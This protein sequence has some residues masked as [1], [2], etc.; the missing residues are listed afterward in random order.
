MFYIGDVT[1]PTE[2]DPCQVVKVHFDSDTGYYFTISVDRNGSPFEKQT[3]EDRLRTMSYQEQ[4]NMM[5]ETPESGGSVQVFDPEA[6]DAAAA[7]HPDFHRQETADV[8]MTNEAIYNQHL[9]EEQEALQEQQ[10]QQYGQQQYHQP[11]QQPYGNY[12]DEEN[13]VNTA[14]APPPIYQPQAV[15]AASNPPVNNATSSSQKTKALREENSW[16]TAGLLVACCLL[17]IALGGVGTVLYLWLDDDDDE[18]VVR[19]TPNSPSSTPAPA[20]APTPSPTAAPTLPPGTTAS[21]TTPAPTTPATRDWTITT[22]GTVPRSDPTDFGSSIAM[23]GTNFMVTGEPRF[24]E[25]YAKEGQLLPFQRSG[26]GEAFVDQDVLLEGTEVSV[27]QF[28]TSLDMILDSSSGL[29]LLAVG[30]TRTKGLEQ[31]NDRFG[32]GFYYEYNDSTAMFEPVGGTL[33]AEESLAETGGLLGYSI[34]LAQT[35]DGTKRIALSSPSSSVLESA[36][37]DVGRIYTFELNETAVEPMWEKMTTLPLIGQEANTFL[38]ASI[39][40][41]TDGSFLVAGA[42]GSLPSDGSASGQVLVYQW[43]GD[44]WNSVTVSSNVGS[45]GA[46]MGHRV[47]W[48]SSSNAWFAVSAPTHDSSRGLVRVY[49]R[50]AGDSF[51]PLGNDIVGSSADDMLGSALCGRSGRLATGT[52]DGEFAVY[53]YNSGS[54]DWEVV[55]SP[56]VPVENST[57]VACAMSDDGNTLT[58]GTDTF[59]I[60]VYDLI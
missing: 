18:V 28:G 2:W 31:T 46:S 24:G 10:E 60:F 42:P 9:E 33:R 36:I 52:S 22:A 6:A 3:T 41:W 8:A 19:V 55:G 25:N 14:A 50:G 27:E 26:P 56:F 11:Y 23:A 29:P 37:L 40:L 48:I 49:Q 44:A 15:H 57:V 58:V 13:N 4:M 12:Y 53:E 59:Q 32:A 34:A 5:N 54:G 17:I 7:G 20:T 16:L 51:A 35:P 30:S 43:D 38:G 47:Q 45:A 39:D 1:K 21:P